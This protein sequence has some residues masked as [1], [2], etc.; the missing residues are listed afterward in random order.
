MTYTLIVTVFLAYA[1]SSEPAAVGFTTPFQTQELC[2][3]A[4]T[5]YLA[6]PMPQIQTQSSAKAVYASKSAI[7]VERAN[8]LTE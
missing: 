8:N 2:E 3:Q 6:E 1:A 5:A 4:K 7:C